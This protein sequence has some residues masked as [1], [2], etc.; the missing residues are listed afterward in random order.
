MNTDVKGKFYCYTFSGLLKAFEIEF[1]STI[2]SSDPDPLVIK[3]AL[4]EQ[5]PDIDVDMISTY[6]PG[7][8]KQWKFIVGDSLLLVTREETSDEATD[9]TQM[10]DDLSQ[11]NISH[12]FTHK[13]LCS[14]IRA[15]DDVP[16]FTTHLLNEM[17]FVNGPF[18]KRITRQGRAFF[19]YTN[20]VRDQKRL[21][22]KGLK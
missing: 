11:F 2:V 19:D 4:K 9:M 21:K 20:F 22:E 13:M 8:A 6:G 18:S 1:P 5:N 17:G 14:I 15:K 12:A 7:E 16:A 3:N 10:I